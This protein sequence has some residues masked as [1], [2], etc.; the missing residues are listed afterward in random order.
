MDVPIRIEPCRFHSC[1][2]QH[3]HYHTGDVSMSSIFLNTYIKFFFLLTPFFLLS[4]FLSMTQD[5]NP[6][7]R[8]KI[9]VKVTIAIIIICII[10]FLTGRQIFAVFGITLDSFRIGTGVLLFLSSITLV[11]G[12]GKALTK[13]PSEDISVVPLAIPVAVGPATTG[14]L[15]VMG[16]EL[17][18]SWEK[19]IGIA[20][21]IAAIISTGIL[22]Y[23]GGAIE[24]VLKRQG[25]LIL[26]KVT[27]LVLAALAAQMIMT[28]IK[29]FL[30]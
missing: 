2:M 22:L 1:G 10:L 4:T 30:Q 25:L 9:A 13:D 11:Q 21:L 20:A 23:L 26:S 29:S 15:M 5:T 27:G 3:L 28:G 12:T 19:A 17:Q 16:V 24:R 8:K 14:A 7:E 6:A 18:R